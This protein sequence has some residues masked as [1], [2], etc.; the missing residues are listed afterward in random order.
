MGSLG[1]EEEEGNIEVTKKEFLLVRAEYKYRENNSSLPAG[2][3]CS[4]KKKF[5]H[6]PLLYSTIYLY[7][8]LVPLSHASG[9]TEF[10]PAHS[11]IFWVF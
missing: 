9:I 1:E 11:L 6:T 2:K 5:M 7:T 4:N 10:L 8:E 3:C